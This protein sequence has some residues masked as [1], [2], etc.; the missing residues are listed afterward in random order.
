M[1]GLGVSPWA[2]SHFEPVAGPSF[3]QAPLHFHPCNSFRQKHLW[4]RVL[5]GGWQPHASLDALS[6]FWRWALQ[7]SSPQCR[8]FHLRSL[9]WSPEKVPR[10]SYLPRLPAFFLLALLAAVLLPDPIPDSVTLSPPSSFLPRSLL[11]SS[12]MIAFF[13]LPSGTE[14]SSLGHFSL[15]TFFSSVDCMLGILNFFCV[16]N[17]DFLVS[18]YHACPFGSELPQSGWYFL[19]PPICL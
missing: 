1:A 7:V 19:V 12:L 18:T 10:I 2:R 13:S 15:S 8:A 4:V 17:I 5:T 6:F 16:A 11:P 9:S 14:A 3:S